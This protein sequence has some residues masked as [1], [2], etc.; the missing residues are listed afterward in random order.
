M[1]HVHT[2]AP[3]FFAALCHQTPTT[4]SKKQTEKGV[5]VALRWLDACISLHQEY[6]LQV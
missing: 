4:S 3:D 1:G 6:P 5:N 2:L